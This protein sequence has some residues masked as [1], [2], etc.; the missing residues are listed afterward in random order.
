[1]ARRIVEFFLNL[2]LRIF[3]VHV[4]GTN[5]CTASLKDS[6]HTTYLQIAMVF[7]LR[8]TQP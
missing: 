7:T 4:H 2:S 3:N 6:K 5:L 8:E 1:M